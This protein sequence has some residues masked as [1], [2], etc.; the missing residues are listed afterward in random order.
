GA[1]W[2]ASGSFSALA[3]GFYN[4]QIRDAAH[5][6]CV[7]ILDG[8]LRI[9]E[10]GPLSATVV[11]YD[12]T[13]NASA[14][15]RIVISL[16]TGGYGTYEYSIGG[17][18]QASGTFTGLAPASYNVQMR[19]AAHTACVATL[20][21]ALVVTEPAA[22]S[23]TVTPTMVSCNGVNDGIISITAA[24]GGYGTYQ[25]TINGGTTWSGSGLFSGLAPG[26]Y[27]VR[28]RDAANPAC[29]RI[30]N[31]ALI[32]TE[33]LALSSA[34]S[35]TNVSCA[36]SGDGTITIS[37]PSGGYGTYEYSVNGGGSWQLSGS[38][39]GLVPGNYNVQ[40]RDA[41]H[42]GCV[43]VLNASLSITQPPILSAVV[44]TVMVTCN[45]ANDGIINI[46][47]PTG[48]YGTYEY[49]VSGGASWQASGSFTGLAPATY[50][51]QI[52][53]AANTACVIVLNSSLV[54]TQPPA[55]TATVTPTNVT[56]NGAADGTISIT[57]PAGGYGTFEYSISGG[58]SW[59]ATGLFTALAPASYNVQ[60]RDKAHTGCVVT[61][62]P[63]L[64]ITEPAV[65][66]AT[67]ASTDVTCN[68]A[69]DG[70]ITITAPVGGYGT[71]GYSV[72][73][74][75]SWQ[76]SG[77]FAG[78]APGSYDIRI[79][80]AANPACVIILNPALLITQPLVLGG[81][82]ASTNVTCNGAG[83]GTITVS[84]PLGGYGTYEYSINGGAAWQASGSFSAL[85][86]GFYNVQIRDAAHTACVR[87]LDGAL[88]ITEPGPLSATV[89]K[90]DVTCNA[91]ADGR[92]VISL[93]TGGYGTYEYSIGG[94]WQASGTFTGLAP[95]SYNV[96]MRDAAHTAC[97]A[98]LNAALV[99]TE[100]AALSATVTPTMVS[101]NGVNDGIISITAAAGG[102]GT[103]QYTING[104]TAW[105]GSGLFT[106]LA[107]GVYDV[108]IRD[109]ANPACA[110]TLAPALAL[111]QP[112]ALTA[113]VASTN[114]SCAGSGDG[115]ITISAPSGGYGTYEY[116]V[117]GGGSWQ[118]SG[119]FSGLV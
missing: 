2:Q 108:R 4:V 31:A 53:D 119:S 112:A 102:Y 13:C 21:A 61:L 55:L 20:N 6:A 75:A 106:G 70:I 114:V 64:V 37:A 33:P 57:S 5:T 40:M 14:D 101:C 52:R 113:T 26:S 39:S 67:V 82:V 49:S 16:P 93:P 91:A 80:D 85:A 17:A 77:S 89:V 23:A 35:S 8:A 51:V 28:I 69:N 11:K 81:T 66:S 94:A 107:P 38:F 115:T 100:P 109:A 103:Y 18:W 7:R 87:I 110:L 42:T 47:S 76:S 90:Y 99:I 24:A 60:I 118:L 48:G 34:L 97:V 41:A 105:S 9:T 15:G 86:P 22:L 84:A 92:I 96:Q 74:G 68:S 19:D 79:R 46:T 65:L 3:P 78:L 25:Y 12:V 83:D 50:N 10:P 98:T 62:N 59:Q 56:C 63:A 45:G 88:R 116:S 36:G 43:K 54:I 1:T 71:Y 73:G 72:N 29:V 27:D 117:N 44:T 32:I 111:T 104:G 58:A 95:A 30:L